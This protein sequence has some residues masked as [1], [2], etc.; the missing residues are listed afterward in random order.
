[1]T[2]VA[3]APPLSHLRTTHLRKVRRRWASDRMSHVTEAHFERR[4]V[5]HDEDEAVPHGE[6]K[7]KVLLNSRTSQKMMVIRRR[8]V[9]L[10]EIESH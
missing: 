4:V 7:R 1:M 2:K 5:R 8:G 3:K 6:N 10:I 9:M